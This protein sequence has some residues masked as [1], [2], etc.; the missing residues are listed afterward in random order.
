MSTTHGLLVVSTAFRRNPRGKPQLPRSVSVLLDCPA[1]DVALA[2]RIVANAEL[3][4]EFSKRLSAALRRVADVPLDAKMPFTGAIRLDRSDEPKRHDGFLCSERDMSVLFGAIRR[5][6]D[7]AAATMS[8][9]NDGEPERKRSR[10]EL[11]GMTMRLSVGERQVTLT[12]KRSVEFPGGIVDVKTRLDSCA[13]ATPKL[14]C[15]VYDN[16]VFRAMHACVTDALDL[17]RGVLD[18]LCELQDGRFDDVFARVQAVTRG[19]MYCGSKLSDPNSIKAGMGPI[20]AG[21]HEAYMDAVRESTLDV[22]RMR[23]AD[24]DL[25]RADAAA[26]FASLSD[27]RSD[28][29]DGLRELLEDDEA[30]LYGYIGR[31]SGLDADAAR[32]ACAD[33]ARIQATNGIWVP[34]LLEDPGMGRAVAAAKVAEHLGQADV[35]G[36]A[37]GLQLEASLACPAV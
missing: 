18:L 16:G 11:D 7:S 10:I 34:V 37:I 3:P 5:M 8:R 22:R 24:L 19:C 14:I 2:R 27:V 35:L 29:L 6:Y 9:A 23:V 28:F 31:A 25:R 30:K 32:A 13:H 26:L 17:Q 4:P 36:K 33:L 21:T 1:C 15:R 12:F 20:C